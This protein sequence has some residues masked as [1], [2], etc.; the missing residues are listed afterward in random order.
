MAKNLAIWEGDEPLAN[1]QLER[2]T[3]ID[4]K[5]AEA[6]EKIVQQADRKI[7]IQ[8]TPRFRAPKVSDMVLLRRF[9]L[10]QRRGSK[11]K[12]RWEGP[13]L[14]GDLAYHG[15]SGRLY[16]LNTKELVRVKKGGLKDRVHLNDLKLYLTRS[17]TATE[18]TD[19]VNLLEYG[20]GKP[21]R[22]LG[23]IYDLRGGTTGLCNKGRGLHV[24]WWDEAQ[25]VG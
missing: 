22:Q 6:A 10:D 25:G 5:R 19:V 17:A 15:K 13:Y 14:L 20:Q 1:Q 24:H 23:G 21:L 16:D 7:E 12:A 8:K 3:R 2:L 4:E 9:I 18:E 11:L